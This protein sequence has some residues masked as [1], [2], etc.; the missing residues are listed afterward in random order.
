MIKPSEDSLL[1]M[2]EIGPIHCLF[3]F[4]VALFLPCLDRTN[5][6][7]HEDIDCSM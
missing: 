1:E 5:G 3:Q 4:Q 7:L 6:G 2:L